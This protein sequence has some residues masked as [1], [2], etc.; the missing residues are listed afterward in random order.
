MQYK[1]PSRSVLMSWRRIKSIACRPTDWC[2]KWWRNN[3]SEKRDAYDDIINLPRPIS[4][5]THRWN[6]LTV[7][8]SFRP[9]AAYMLLW[10]CKGNRPADRQEIWVWWWHGWNSKPQIS[11]AQW[12]AVLSSP[13]RNNHFIKDERKNGGVYVK[14]A[15]IVRKIDE[16]KHAVVFEDGTVVAMANISKIEFWP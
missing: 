9:S 15:G 4:K 11:T 6:T 16:Y 3:W 8:L 1:A 12:Y 5:N 14:T 13:C 2:L 7:R 10:S